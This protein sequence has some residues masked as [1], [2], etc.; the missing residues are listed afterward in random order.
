MKSRENCVSLSAL[1]LFVCFVSFI[2]LFL[3]L[4]YFLTGLCCCLSGPSSELLRKLQN[5]SDKK[6]GLQFEVIK[7]S[8]KNLSLFS[9]IL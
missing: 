6:S 4:F 5:F 1:T 3:F 8:S 9:L 2:I 7:E